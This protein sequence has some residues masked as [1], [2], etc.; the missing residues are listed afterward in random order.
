MKRLFTR[1]LVTS[2]ILMAINVMASAQS[3]IDFETVGQ[4]WSWTLFENGDNSPTLY[5]VVANPD[6]SGINASDNCAKYIINEGAQPWAGLWSADMDDFTFTEANAVIKVMVYKDVLSP[7]GLKFEN[8][9][10]SVAVEVKVANT[11]VN[12]W[13][14]LTFD[15][16]SHIG[17]SVTKI[18]FFP[19]F[20]AARTAGSTSYFDNIVFEEGAATVLAEPAIAAP[21]P[22]IVEANTIS[23]YSDAYTNIEGTNFNPGWGQTTEVSTVDI[24]GNATMKYQ[25]LNYQGIELGSQ[26]DASQMTYLNLHVWTP[27][28]TSL[29]LFPISASTGEK[30][31]SLAPLTLETCNTFSIPL[32]DFTDQGLSMADII[33][34]KFEGSG[35]KT[36]YIDN[37]YFST[38]TP[39]S[40]GASV[41]ISDL[42]FFPNPVV[43]NLTI[44][45]DS[46]IQIVSLR[47]LS[48]KVVQSLLVNNSEATINLQSI[49]TGLYIMSV[50]YV[51]GEIT[52]HKISKL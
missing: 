49:A 44:S 11:V 26:I 46:E 36:V 19:D 12:E 1:V 34:F 18:V 38:E 39:T 6:N 45:A 5:S 24:S 13:E 50:E 9:D 15:F 52:N 20:P 35:G 29:L 8:E 23:I 28:E 40:T 14:E 41:K 51:S 48:G 47:N 37:L 22:D 7:F 4:D 30:S 3:S 33:Q 43:S 10:A 25:S 32:S 27:N 42:S 17:K 21:T 16:T 2:F 31:V